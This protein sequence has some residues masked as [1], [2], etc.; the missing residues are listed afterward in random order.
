MKLAFDDLEGA[1]PFALFER[2]ADADDGVEVPAERGSD[3]LGDDRVGLSEE[4]PPLAVAHDHPAAPGLDEHRRADLAGEGARIPR[5]EVLR[6]DLD[7]AAIALVR[8]R[9]E[10]RE[11]RGDHQ[12]DVRQGEGELRELARQLHAAR[13]AVVHLPVARDERAPDHVHVPLPLPGPL[14]P[15]AVRRTSMPGS[16]LPSMSSSDAPPPV[17]MCFIFA[18]MSLPAA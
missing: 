18:A 14:A 4:L 5:I 10:R 3:L 13:A 1:A 8:A 11:R 6:A 7:A 15:S 9:G 17:E 16:F 2:L 12:V